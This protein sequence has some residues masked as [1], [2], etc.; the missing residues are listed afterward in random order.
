M[1]AR[2]RNLGDAAAGALATM[3]ALTHLDLGYCDKVGAGLSHGTKPAMLICNVASRNRGDW[4]L[5]SYANIMQ[6]EQHYIASLRQVTSAVWDTLEPLKDGLQELRLTRLCPE[7]GATL[8]LF[9]N[10]TLQGFCCASWP[11]L[12]GCVCHQCPSDGPRLVVYGTRCCLLA[13]VKFLTG[14]SQAVAEELPS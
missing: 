6:S 9:G 7:C 1:L 13:V 12:S 3:T 11:P 10:V 2:H 5:P 4:T 8:C 14:A